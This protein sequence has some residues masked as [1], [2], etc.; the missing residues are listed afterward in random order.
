MDAEETHNYHPVPIIRAKRHQPMFPNKSAETQEPTVDAEETRVKMHPNPVLQGKR[1]QPRFETI[2][3]DQE[4]KSAEKS[5][6]QH[7][8]PII[9][10][11]RHQPM[12]PNKSAET[13]EPT[14]DVEETRVKMYPNPVLQGKRNQPRFETTGADQK[15]QDINVNKTTRKVHPSPVIRAKLHQHE[16]RSVDWSKAK[17]SISSLFSGFKSDGSVS[18]KATGKRYRG[19]PGVTH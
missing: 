17:E 12:F 13:Q 14:V 1:N 9:N 4:S 15:T 16:Y 3:G 2:G 7:S 6:I 8:V 10:A 18:H 19:K 5:N 11:K